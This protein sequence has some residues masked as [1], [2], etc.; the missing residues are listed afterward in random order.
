MEKS[1]GTQE[2]LDFW[3]D[4]HRV[5]EK[6]ENQKTREKSKVPN[7]QTKRF[8]WISLPKKDCT[9]DFLEKNIDIFLL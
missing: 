3:N 5:G 6:G 1:P 4:V 7:Q 8:G 9:I 2:T